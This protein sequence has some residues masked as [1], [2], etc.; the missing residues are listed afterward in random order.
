MVLRRRTIAKITGFVVGILLAAQFGTYWLMVGR[1]VIWTVDRFLPQNTHFSHGT[2]F[3]FACISDTTAN[4]LPHA[5]KEA[6][7]AHLRHWFP[8]VY[9]NKETIPADAKEERTNTKTG[10]KILLGLKGG[11]LLAM[12]VEKR[13][14]M[15]FRAGYADWEG[16]LAASSNQAAFVWIL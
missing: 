14:F 4:A 12:Q 3:A 2:Q 9:D 16:N 8:T 6:L 7:K 13:G 10:E 1:R 11:C 15:W 5:E